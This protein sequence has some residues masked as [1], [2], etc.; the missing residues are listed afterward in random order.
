V[1]KPKPPNRYRVS[2]E[3]WVTCVLCHT[4]EDAES[5]YWKITDTVKFRGKR[6]CRQ[7]FGWRFNHKLWDEAPFD[8]ELGD[9]RDRKL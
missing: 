6:Y 8:I 3:K 5:K 1:I 9:D 4:D 7:H 2:H